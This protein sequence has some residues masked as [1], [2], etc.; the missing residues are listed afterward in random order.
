MCRYRSNIHTSGNIHTNVK[1]QI[2]CFD[3][4]LGFPPFLDK[5]PLLPLAVCFPAQ[6]VPSEKKSTLK[7]KNLFPVG[8]NSLFNVD[9]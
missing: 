6:Q 4:L 8:A 3:Y 9:P 7:G 1:L 5:G 2:N